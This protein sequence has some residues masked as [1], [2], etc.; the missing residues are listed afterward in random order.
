MADGPNRGEM[1][2]LYRTI[3]D[4]FRG[5]HERLD[6]LNGRTGESERNIAALAAT[7]REVVKDVE[8][9]QRHGIRRRRTDRQGDGEDWAGAMTKRERWLVGL[10]LVVVTFAVEALRLLGSKAWETIAAVAPKH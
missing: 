2:R 9:L 3:D 10:G 7:Q 8:D 5:I 4:G 6:K 1:D